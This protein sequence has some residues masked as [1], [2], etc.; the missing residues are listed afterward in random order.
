MEAGIIGIIQLRKLSDIFF[1]NGTKTAVI[2][3]SKTKNSI[4]VSGINM[5]FNIDLEMLIYEI[6]ANSIKKL[7]NKTNYL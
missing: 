7:I 2:N 3:P 6:L 5:I 1:I 4:K